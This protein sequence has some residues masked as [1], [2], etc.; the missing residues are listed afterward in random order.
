[1]IQ[2]LKSLSIGVFVGMII[3]FAGSYLV[4]IFSIVLNGLGD[5]LQ[6][7]PDKEWWFMTK[8]YDK[9]AHI[10]VPLF[11][12]LGASVAVYDIFSLKK[13]K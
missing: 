12:L 10:F 4:P 7:F 2:A 8:R 1:M 9:L 11:G 6:L 5:L 13:S 3:G